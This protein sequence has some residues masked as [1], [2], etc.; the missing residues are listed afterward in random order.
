[1]KHIIAIE[2][3]P[4]NQNVLARLFSTSSGSRPAHRLSSPGVAVVID[5]RDQHRPRAPDQAVAGTP[6]G[7]AI[8]STE[9]PPP[10]DLSTPSAFPQLL[11]CGHHH[12]REAQNAI[13]PSDV[14]VRDDALNADMVIR[15]SA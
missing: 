6:I 15:R 9:V 4:H 12:G 8:R 2:E 10:Y 13:V 5:P 11:P 1:V 3:V 14:A 7:F